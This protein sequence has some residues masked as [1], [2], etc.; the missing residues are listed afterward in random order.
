MPHRF[1]ITAW[2]RPIPTPPPFVERGLPRFSVSPVHLVERGLPRFGV[3][4]RSQEQRGKPR[5]T[6]AGNRIACVTGVNWVALVERGL[7]RFHDTR[8]SA[9]SHA[10]QER[11]STLEIITRYPLTPPI[12]IV[13]K[14]LHQTS[15][16][17]IGDDVI[18]LCPQIFFCPQ[19]MIEKSRLPD[20]T[21]P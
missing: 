15:P 16:N 14:G 4:A 18:G 19:A 5:S 10:L 11:N 1:Y 7:P 17:G 8:R 3:R 2:P 9:A 12:R 21:N 13:A 20:G 6:R